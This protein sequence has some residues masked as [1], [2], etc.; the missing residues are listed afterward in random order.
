VV[1]QHLVMWHDPCSTETG[2][3]TDF[4]SQSNYKD[5]SFVL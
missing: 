2:S 3:K 4:R 1:N 5:Q